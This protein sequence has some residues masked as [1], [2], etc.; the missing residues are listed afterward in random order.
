MDKNRHAGYDIRK[1]DEDNKRYSSILDKP[2]KEIDEFSSYC[3]ERLN[4]ETD[5][6][7]A[8]KLFA[9]W[10]TGLIELYSRTNR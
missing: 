9:N 7:E 2:S 1:E 6:E 4:K 5:S 3:V 10:V 8:K